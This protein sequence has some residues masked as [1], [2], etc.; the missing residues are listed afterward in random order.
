MVVPRFSDDAKNVS[1]CGVLSLKPTRQNFT[2][3]PPPRFD[4]IL[5]RQGMRRLSHSFDYVSHG[6]SQ[7]S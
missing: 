2:T 1:I 4:Q 3:D 6:L 5:Q 7:I